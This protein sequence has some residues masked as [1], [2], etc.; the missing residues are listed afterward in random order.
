VLTSCPISYQDLLSKHFGCQLP[1]AP[2][3]KKKQGGSS[4][5]GR[6]I[7]STVSGRSKGS[8]KEVELS[9]THT[10]THTR[11]L[12]MS[13]CETGCCGTKVEDNSPDNSP[14]AVEAGG[15]STGC[16]DSKESHDQGHDHDHKEG[17]HSHDHHHHN[18]HSHDHSHEEHSE[19][20]NQI[21]HGHEHS[22]EVDEEEDGGVLC[23]AVVRESG[24]DISLFDASGEVRS[25]SYK[26]DIRKLCFSSHGQEADDLLTPCFDDAGNH[27]SP[28]EGCFCGVETPHLHAHVHDPKTCNEDSPNTAEVD[29]MKLARM[30]LHPTEESKNSSLFQI[31]VSERLPKE[32]NSKDF[33]HH[34]STS[35]DSLHAPLKK[36]RMHKV[37][38]SCIWKFNFEM[39]FLKLKTGHTHLFLFS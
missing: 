24:A 15:C 35:G 21:P 33:V 12:K 28:E 25:F 18:G 37:K 20:P 34:L 5:L 3:P 13:A 10:H 1:R 7:Y 14:P 22:H 8:L 16:C 26:G 36:R 4:S 29:L 11:H 31:P 17:H 39:G 9:T 30:T 23:L 2:P 6:I 19:E 32:C 27:G 38:V